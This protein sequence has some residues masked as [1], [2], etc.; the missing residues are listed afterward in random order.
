MKKNKLI[1][2]FLSLPILCLFSWTLFL[3]IQ[4]ETWREI[5]VSIQWYDPVDLLSGH[6][7]QY[8]IDWYRTDCSQFENNICPQPEVFCP[9]QTW[10][11]QCR[12]YIP[13]ENA[14]E[15]DNLFRQRNLENMVFEV[16]YS[17]K[18]WHTPIA[19]QLLIN[20]KDWKEYL[21]KE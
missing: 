18:I 12:F 17:Y 1:A 6:Y 21:E 19:K 15:L 13:E 14:S 20:K 9:K 7:I 4:R 16:L 10:W 11:N 2:I 3:L 8:Q 5:I